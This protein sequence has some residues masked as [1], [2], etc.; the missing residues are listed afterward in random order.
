MGWLINETLFT[1]QNNNNLEAVYTGKNF[2]LTLP[3]E[4]EASSVGDLSTD[5]DNDI[6]TLEF[7]T[8]DGG[9][10]VLLSSIQQQQLSNAETL[11]R[12]QA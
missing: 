9:T 2:S 4:V 7:V 5:F 6:F 11:T 3:S 10:T 8:D 12:I 1:C